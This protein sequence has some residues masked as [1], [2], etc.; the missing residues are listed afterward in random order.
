MF[1]MDFTAWLHGN[2]EDQIHQKW[3]KPGYFVLEVH[4]FVLGMGY[5][6]L[7]VGYFL[8]GMGRFG[9][10]GGHLVPIPGSRFSCALDFQIGAFVWP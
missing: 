6:G 10:G 7:G 4:H 2:W 5:F 8:L 3:G 1:Q 9:L